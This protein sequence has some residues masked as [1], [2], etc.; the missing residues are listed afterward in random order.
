MI[1]PRCCKNTNGGYAHTCTPTPR[2]RE[3]EKQRDELQTKADALVDA[4]QKAAATF[5]E[6]EGAHSTDRLICR[7]AAQDIHT[8]LSTYKEQK[9]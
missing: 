7:E 3:L 1:C 4:L 6:V 5:N 9:Q 2:W 8:T